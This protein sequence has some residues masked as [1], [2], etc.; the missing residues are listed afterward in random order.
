MLQEISVLVIWPV[1][2]SYLEKGI[3]A[4]NDVDVL[5]AGHSISSVAVEGKSWLVGSAATWP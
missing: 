3:L 1:G 2:I 5:L 4:N